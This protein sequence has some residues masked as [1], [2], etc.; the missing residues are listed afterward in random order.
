MKGQRVVS[1]SL[2]HLQ[3][4]GAATSKGPRF[5]HELLNTMPRG[6]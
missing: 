4:K 2:C 5:A 1:W 3:L 6:S